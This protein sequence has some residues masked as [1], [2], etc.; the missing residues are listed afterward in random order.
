MK[1]QT[2]FILLLFI[3]SCSNHL[4]ETIEN[5]DNQNRQS[6]LTF[7]YPET[8]YFSTDQNIIT[9]TG[10]A[11]DKGGI[12]R[13]EVSLNGKAYEP[14]DGKNIWNRTLILQPGI[15]KINSHII[16]SKGSIFKIAPRYIYY[17]WKKINLKLPRKISHFNITPY[18]NAFLITGGRNE[19]YDIGTIAL[20]NITHFSLNEGTLFDVG[21]DINILPTSL[22]NTAVY[23]NQLISWG[24]F[25]SSENSLSP[26]YLAY[27][28]NI[29]TTCANISDENCSKGGNSNLTEMYYTPAPTELLVTRAASP[30]IVLN[31]I[32]YV[33][34]GVD[35]YGQMRDTVVKWDLTELDNP[36]EG[37]VMVKNTGIFIK[38]THAIEHNNKIW[39][40]GGVGGPTLHNPQYLDTIYVYDPVT[41]VIHLHHQ[42]LNA[43]RAGMAIVKLNDKVYLI[44][45]EDS[46]G[47]SLNKI[48]TFNL[49]TH[50]LNELIPLP[51]KRKFAATVVHENKIYL[52][53]G[54]DEGENPTKT[55]Y[56]Y[57]PE[58]EQ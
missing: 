9:I 34:G 22:P 35:V 2:F 31:N 55:I 30:H 7:T 13:I 43:K 1:R 47:R 24:G 33:I 36:P 52:L 37:W 40:F 21:K 41:N 54:R 3:I 18:N 26:I 53:G 51:I 10:T 58:L 57:N 15:N 28:L 45:G 29:L 20:Q 5:I 46:T 56:E 17:F 48:E 25:I 32:F 39:I 4:S 14:A 12:K 50:E 49:N 11:Y 44:G 38:Y 23:N 8:P 16:N 42:K 19:F 6:H 27:N